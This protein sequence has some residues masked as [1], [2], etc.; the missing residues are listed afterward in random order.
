MT[1]T[2]RRA[3]GPAGPVDATASPRAVWRTLP[4]DAVTI[5]GGI[6]AKRQAV[7]REAALPHG[8]RMLE[9]AGNFE[10][11]RISAGRSRAA[12]RGPVFMDSDVYK[13]LEAASF[14]LARQPSAELEALIEQAIDV[15]EP[16]QQADGYLNSYY[17]VAEP[18]RRWI[19]FG[20]GHELYCAGHLFQAAVAHHRATGRERL[21]GI[22]RRFADHID[23]TFGP[24]KRQ[25]TPGHPEIEMALVELYR[26]TGERRYL[27]LAGFLLDQRGHGWLGPSLRYGA[28]AY[29]QDRVPIR[30]ASE[31]EGHAVRAL[32][33][34]AG[35]A[36]V[37][38]ETGDRALLDALER[39][40]HDLVARKLYITGGVGSRHLAEAFGQPYELPNELA[41]CETCAA[42]ASIMWCWRMLLATGQSRFADLAER[43]LYN[44]VL[45]GVS[46]DG[47]LY[48]YVNPLADNGEPEHLHRGGPSRKPWHTV[49]CCPPNVMRLFASLGH[50]LAT[51]DEG[52]LQ[53]HQ[54]GAARIAADLGASGS[55]AL[56]MASEYPWDGRVR[57]VVEEGGSGAW[58]LSLRVPAWADGASARLNGEPV[59][60]TPDAGGYLRIARTWQ[61][62]DAVELELPMPPR[63]TEAHPWIESTRGCAAIERGPLVYCLE[64]A[65]Q[66]APVYDLEIDRSAPLRASWRPD[67]LDGVSVVRGSGFR[68]DRSAWAGV[69]YRPLRGEAASPKQPVELTAVPVYAW[70]NRGPGAMKVWLPLG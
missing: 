45:S 9:Q 41:Y 31:L 29:F 58:T 11:L 32:Y 53:L 70:A 14:E 68:I 27:D 21:L 12:Y 3:A 37:Y 18:G 33:L 55:A 36:D 61:R 10:N 56:R 60:A 8:F 34:T 22:A 43:T 24:G 4:A 67:L 28:S 2:S 13:W 30:E 19:D 15:V 48:F 42:I 7:N 51:C 62:G 16:A 69:L 5:E 65:D 47:Q 23:A 54:Y 66:Q 52:G 40:W 64:Q 35:V 17:T 6:W 39:Q 20:H 49:A 1:T 26:E 46:L 59:D 25:A 57:I 50:Y 63:L 38:L 44:A